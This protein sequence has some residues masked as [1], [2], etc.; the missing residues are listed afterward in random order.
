MPELDHYTNERRV[1][2]G[3]QHNLGCKCEPPYWLRLSTPIEQAREAVRRSTPAQW[4]FMVTVLSVLERRRDEL[5][6]QLSAREE[7]SSGA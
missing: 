6:A 7:P 2:P 1:Q 5:K 4:D 3:C